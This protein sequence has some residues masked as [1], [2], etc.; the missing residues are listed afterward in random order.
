MDFNFTEEQLMIQDVA[1]R[2]AQ[3]KIA[4]SAEHH[5]RTG[6][7]PLDNIRTL[8]E[9]GLMGIE[10]PAEYG[11]AGLGVTEAAIMMHEVAS[12]GGGMAAASAV[13]INLFGLNPV[14]VFGSEE[15]R[16]RMLPPIA[17]GEV[18]SCFGVTEPNAG[19]DTTRISTRARRDGD[20][21]VINGRKVW[22]SKALE[23][24]RILLL[25]QCDLIEF[26]SQ[27]LH[28]SLFIL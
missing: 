25:T 18:K 14:A 5:D 9:N 4:P 26:C 22:T 7:F 2:L 20:T 3:E 10:V 12:H 27:N 13:H 24:D 21:Y 28:R 1:R 23:A 15:Q 17:R 6:E 8:G 11:G 19:T 16:R